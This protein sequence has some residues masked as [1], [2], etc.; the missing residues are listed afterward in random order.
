MP[1][2]SAR[3]LHVLVLGAAL[4][5]CGGGGGSRTDAP[6]PQGPRRYQ[7]NVTLDPSGVALVGTLAEGM[8]VYDVVANFDRPDLAMVGFPD[9]A[10]QQMRVAPDGAVWFSLPDTE[11]KGLYRATPDW[12]T[13]DEAFP[14]YWSYPGAPTE[15]D[16]HLADRCDT[17][18]RDAVNAFVIQQG[19]G[20]IAYRCRIGPGLEWYG[21]DGVV[22][23][24][25]LERVRAWNENGL[26]LATN[27]DG[28]DGV[29]SPDGTWWSLVNHVMAGPLDIRAAR[30]HGDG[31]WVAAPDLPAGLMPSAMWRFTISSSG[32]ATVDGE[33]AAAPEGFYCGS[34]DQDIGYPSSEALSSAGDLYGIGFGPVIS[35]WRDV[36]C[37]RRLQPSTTEIVYDE[38]LDPRTNAVP[39]PADHPEIWVRINVMA[40]RLI[41]G[42]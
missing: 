42:P 11:A 30:A 33:F 8:S 9:F 26:M 12:F 16:L 3:R 23:A 7:A 21:A 17:D 15:N 28:V 4:C 14:Q 27:R 2:D 1:N 37:R 39:A 25:D 41:T 34:P 35:T 38:G 32:F 18:P 6:P 36:V 10:I 29:L 5:A 31:F 24:R 40:S 22:L 19:T 13:Q 20:K